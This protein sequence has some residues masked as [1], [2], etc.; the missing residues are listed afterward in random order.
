MAFCEDQFDCAQVLKN[1]AYSEETFPGTDSAGQYTF[2]MYYLGP[3][4]GIHFYLILT[5][6]ISFLHVRIPLALWV[7]TYIGI[8]FLA[9]QYVKTRTASDLTRFLRSIFRLV[10]K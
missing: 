10:G 3:K 2:K 9:G 8:L 7:S 5:F 4:V 6:G 1:F